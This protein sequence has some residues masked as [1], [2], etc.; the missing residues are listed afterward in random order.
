M[1][2]RRVTSIAEDPDLE[3]FQDFDV[4]DP[5]EAPL[6][7]R[8]WAADEDEHLKM[9]VDE[10]G[11][12]S[13]AHIATYLHMRNGKQCR[14]R[15]RNHLRPQ[16]HKGEW[17]VDEDTEIWTRVQEMG[18]KW[19]QISEL[20]M[21]NRTDNDIKNRW[22]SIIRKS[23]AP[24]GREWTAEE[25]DLRNQF[26]GKGGHPPRSE[27][28]ARTKAARAEG[29]EGEGR[30][31]ASRKREAP[32]APKDT[33]PS[34][35]RKLFKSPG[36]AAEVPAFRPPTDPLPNPL[37]SPPTSNPP[38]PSPP[39][40]EQELRASGTGL[41]PALDGRPALNTRSKSQSNTPAGPSVSQTPSSAFRAILEGEISAESFD[42]ES[43]LPEL[44]GGNVSSIISG[45]SFSPVNA[46]FT[47][48]SLAAWF[49]DLDKTVSPLL[50]LASPT[51]VAA[52]AAARGQPSAL[53]RT[54]SHVES[55]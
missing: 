5:E 4:Q 31:R 35:H 33:S 53:G 14:E 47:H 55:A 2:G 24:G 46:K 48:A 39:Q 49:D 18:T 45:L 44:S 43:Y 32:K 17:S 7:R 40:V 20:Y 29:E 23:H 25:T 36:F 8:P 54:S 6:K 22:N 9:L 12:K 13:W 15:W 34:A 3:V 50:P 51:A 19:A 30:P 26:L 16:L 10:H 52:A 27:M 1:P 37:V 42:A 11:V 21:P 41:S 38:S 28:A